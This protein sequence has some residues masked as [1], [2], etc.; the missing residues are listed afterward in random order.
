MLN[1][2]YIVKF[3]K[4]LCVMWIIRDQPATF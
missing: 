4:Q 3:A 1:L 2:M